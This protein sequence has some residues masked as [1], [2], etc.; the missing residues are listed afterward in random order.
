MK[1]KHHRLK[2]IHS[3]V[4]MMPSPTSYGS[5][6]LFRGLTTT[7]RAYLRWKLEWRSIARGNSRLWEA[8]AKG[9]HEWKLKQEMQTN[10]HQ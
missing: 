7:D 8:R 3:G 6:Q 1:R 9:Y 4:D 10:D 2:K 5:I